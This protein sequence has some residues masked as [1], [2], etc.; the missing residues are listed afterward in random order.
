MTKIVELNIGANQY[1]AG[2]S[3]T[4]T[5][6]LN[7][8][9]V[10]AP[11]WK[12]GMLDDNYQLIDSVGTAFTISHNT[13]DTLEVVGTPANGAYTLIPLSHKTGFIGGTSLILDASKIDVDWMNAV[14]TIQRPVS[15]STQKTGY[16]EG[17]AYTYDP[18]TLSMSGG[19]MIQQGI[20]LF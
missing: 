7:T 11:I 16:N 17:D 12:E 1:Y 14:L 9:E 8:F 20:L 13:T 5:G 6:T 19:R 3:G 15:K 4:G 10:S 18:V 2:C